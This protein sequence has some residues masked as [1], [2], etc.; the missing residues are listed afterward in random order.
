MDRFAA[1]FRDDQVDR[2]V[3]GLIAQQQCVGPLHTPLADVAVL[4]LSH[5][6]T[7][8]EAGTSYQ[9]VCV[10]VHACMQAMCVCLNAEERVHVWERVCGCMQV[11]TCNC[12]CDHTCKQLL[13]GRSKIAY[14]YSCLFAYIQLSMG[15]H[16]QA[17]TGGEVRVLST[18]TLPWCLHE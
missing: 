5:H 1:P 18:S 10:C 9:C 3:T 11:P 13:A 2:S 4:A 16:L 17:I 14:F 6:A 15:V 7:V 12:Q 8:S